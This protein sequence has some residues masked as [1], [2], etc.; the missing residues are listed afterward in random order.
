MCLCQLEPSRKNSSLRL[1]GKAQ[2]EYDSGSHGGGGGHGLSFG[3][4][5]V[6]LEVAAGLTGH[7][8]SIA[9]A[10]AIAAIASEVAQSHG[11]PAELHGYETGYLHEVP[12]LAGAGWHA[13]EHESLANGCLGRQLSLPGIA[14]DA[15]SVEVLSWPHGEITPGLTGPKEQIRRLA[16]QTK[17]V[18]FASPDIN[19]AGV[20]EIDRTVDCILPMGPSRDPDKQQCLPNGWYRGATGAT[21]VWREFFRLPPFFGVKDSFEKRRT[22]LVV[23]GATWYYDQTADY[24]TRVAFSVYSLPFAELNSWTYDWDQIKG[25]RDLAERLSRRLKDYLHEYPASAA[26]IEQR[27]TMGPR[28]TEPDVSPGE[29][30]ARQARK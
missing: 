30:S 1:S 13:P 6:G 24:E 2:V 9:D 20:V 14:R 7:S 27:R 4:L 19:I 11:G 23:T 18:S 25:Y 15:T 12:A 22:F 16:K 8:L 17:M 5:F 26:A 3:D 10:A 29:R 21:H 28:A